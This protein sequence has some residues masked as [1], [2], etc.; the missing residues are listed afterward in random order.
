[1]LPGCSC[2]VTMRG[3]FASAKGCCLL[4]FLLSPTPAST[5]RTSVPHW[6]DLE[7]LEEFTF[8]VFVVAFDKTYKDESEYDL[9][10]D[11][12]GSNLQAILDHNRAQLDRESAGGY[13][14]H[15]NEFA[16]L[17]PDELPT[18]NVKALRTELL[19]NGMSSSSLRLPL[20]TPLSSL[21][22][23]VSWKAKGVTTPVKHQGHCGSCWAFASIA[24]LESHVALQTGALFTLS[25]QQ[26]VSCSDN[27]RHCGG[28]GGCT[29]A[30]AEVAY[31]YVQH[32]GVVEEWIFGYQSY[33]GAQVNC[34]LRPA[35]SREE[36]DTGSLRRQ[37]VESS[38]SPSPYVNDAVAAIL[39]YANLEPNNYLVLMNAVAKLGPVTVSVACS[40]WHLYKSGVFSVEFNESIQQTTDVNHLVVLE[41]YGTDEETGEDYWLI[42]NSWGTCTRIE[43]PITSSTCSD[44]CIVH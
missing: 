28:A 6:T 24:A 42:R 37:V 12:Y 23:S 4:F 2:T 29:G 15:V 17:T 7:A 40:T 36:T 31:Q 20:D 18:G 35:E 10:R 30:T 8:D 1:M 32:H 34:T 16:D 22:K 25:V 27:V 11:V 38:S 21:P 9:R 41:G 13:F 14:L 19:S 33:N 26:L 39:G 43:F 5:R 3:F 44:G